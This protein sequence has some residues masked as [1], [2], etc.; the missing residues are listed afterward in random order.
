MTRI[1]SLNEVIQKVRIKLSKWKVESLSVGGRLTLLNLALV[2][3]LTYYMSLFKAPDGVL[4]HLKRL[5]NSFFLG[6]ETGLWLNVIKAIHGSN[7]SLDQPPL[8]CC[9]TWIFKRMLQFAKFQNSDFAVSFR[10]RPRGGI[11]ES[12]FQE[13]SI[14][15]SSVVLSSSSN[16][17]VWT[18]NGHGDFLVKSVREEIDNQLLVTSSSSMRWSKMLPIKLNVFAWCMFLDKLP[19]GINLSN[20]GLDVPCVLSLNYGNEVK[21]RNH[22]LFI[23]SMDLDLFWLL[24]RWWNIDIVNLIDG[25]LFLGI[26]V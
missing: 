18:L 14:L 19:T 25:S 10:R 13:L 3:L 16:R 15:L 11:E 2:S 20:R 22:I 7:G 4:S 26:M 17:W 1:N 21:S 24:G 23:C 6:A 8:T 12:Q 9:L 5:C